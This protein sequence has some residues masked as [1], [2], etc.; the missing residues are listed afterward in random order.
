MPMISI[1]SL[2]LWEILSFFYTTAFVVG[3]AIVSFYIMI[4][5]STL[6]EEVGWRYNLFGNWKKYRLYEEDAK[7]IFWSQDVYTDYNNHKIKLCSSYIRNGD[8]WK[9][10]ASA[11]EFRKKYHPELKAYFCTEMGWDT[12]IHYRKETIIQEIKE[13]TVTDKNNPF[14]PLE[15]ETHE[16]Q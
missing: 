2:I 13:L 12:Y 14:T 6:F 9:L 10:E 7:N 15:E 4:T 8:I 16:A 11:I 5:I 1:I 3:I